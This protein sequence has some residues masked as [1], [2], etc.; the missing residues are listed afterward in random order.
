MCGVGRGHRAVE[1]VDSGHGHGDSGRCNGGVLSY[2]VLRGRRRGGGGGWSSGQ[3][4]KWMK[5]R[6]GSRRNQVH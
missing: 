4:M 1:E 5:T 3:G 6:Q 2:G